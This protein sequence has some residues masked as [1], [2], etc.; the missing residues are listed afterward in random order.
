MTNSLS[1]QEPMTTCGIIAG[2]PGHPTSEVA[3]QYALGL[4]GEQIAVAWYQE[5]GYTALETRARC[6]AGEIDAVVEAPDGT[7]VFLEV[8]TRRGRSYGGAE[9]V[10]SKKLATMRR[11]AAEWLERL[12][13]SHRSAGY[14]DVR[15]DAVEIVLNGAEYS[16]TRFVGVEDGAC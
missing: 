11:C 4:A 5:L 13:E 2:T 7:L 10:G 15:F 12:P 16:A 8:K 1:T 14:A 3:D 6:R 9:S